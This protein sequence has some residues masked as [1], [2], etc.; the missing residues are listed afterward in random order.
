[1]SGRKKI[2]YEDL[3]NTLKKHADRLKMTFE[4]DRITSD[5]EAALITV[6]ADVVSYLHDRFILANPL[7]LLYL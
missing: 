7:F 2:F 3:F 5:F 6:V 1:M 4:P